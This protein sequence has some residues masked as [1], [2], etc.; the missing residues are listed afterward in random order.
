MKRLRDQSMSIQAFQYVNGQYNVRIIINHI[1]IT[2]DSF[3]VFYT[4]IR[5]ELINKKSCKSLR[6]Q[7]NKQGKNLENRTW[8]KPELNPEFLPRSVRGGSFGWPVKLPL[9]A[10][11]STNCLGSPSCER[12]RRPL[13]SYRLKL[14]LVQFELQIFA[15]LSRLSPTCFIASRLI[16]L[17]IFDQLQS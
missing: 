8:N 10:T 16:L 15:V 17:H 4:I 1:S 12:F 13:Q 7:P 14:P 5:Q 3:Q 9:N 11:A 6:D 2:F